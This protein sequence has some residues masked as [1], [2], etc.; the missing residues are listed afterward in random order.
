M[1][2]APRSKVGMRT[3]GSFESI[4][5]KSNPT[6][7][8]PLFFGENS[9]SDAHSSSEATSF[10]SR[11]V[12]SLSVAPKDTLT[13]TPFLKIESVSSLAL[14]SVSRSH[15]VRT[16]ATDMSDVVKV[17]SS[18]T[19][20]DATAGEHRDIVLGYRRDLELDLF[21]KQR[22]RLERKQTKKAVKATRRAVKPPQESH[23]ATE[24]ND[25]HKHNQKLTQRWAMEMAVSH[26]LDGL[27]AKM[28][29]P[30]AENFSDT[31]DDDDD[32]DKM[33]NVEEAVGSEDGSECMVECH[34]LDT[35]DEH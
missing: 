19:A 5:A 4:S 35:S 8:P 31:D 7:S 33:D 10:H 27:F 20:A 21:E 18:Q 14:D 22:R 28:D 17:L 32:E 11:P 30:Y 23:A 12:S 16:D 34:L 1:L 25:L 9:S 13:S 24:V 2:P 26:F 6:P 15:T 29:R 3:Y